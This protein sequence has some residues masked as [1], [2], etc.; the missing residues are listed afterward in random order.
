MVGALGVF[1]QS[2]AEVE[3]PSDQVGNL[4]GFVIG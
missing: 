1:A 3:A 4:T 2:E